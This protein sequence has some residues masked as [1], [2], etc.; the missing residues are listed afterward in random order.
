MSNLSQGKVGQLM[1]VLATYEVPHP[2]LKIWMFFYLINK[3]KGRIQYM[4]FIMI[5][6]GGASTNSSMENLTPAM[7]EVMRRK[8]EVCFNF[9]AEFS[10]V[11]TTCPLQI[12]NIFF[13]NLRLLIDWYTFSKYLA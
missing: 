2:I 9:A 10:V 11:S 3:K 7:L 6:L 8:K 5:C 1:V 12:F 13:L 4:I